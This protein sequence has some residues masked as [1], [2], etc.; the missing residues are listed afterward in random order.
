MELIK[1]TS[2]KCRPHYSSLTLHQNPRLSVVRYLF[3]NIFFITPTIKFCFTNEY[4]KCTLSAFILSSL[5]AY[6]VSGVKS[7]Y[8]TVHS[9][10]HPAQST[11]HMWGSIA[12]P[13]HPVH[14]WHTHPYHPHD[15]DKALFYLLSLSSLAHPEPPQSLGIFLKRGEWHFNSHHKEEWVSLDAIFPFEN[16]S[17]VP[18]LCQAEGGRKFT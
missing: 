12:P 3:K 18:L 6:T 10:S 4:N 1:K 16:I 2:F 13:P 7:V 9:H 11:T 17:A 5:P 8:S 14:R 15:F